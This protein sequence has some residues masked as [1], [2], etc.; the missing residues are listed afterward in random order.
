MMDAKFVIGVQ[1]TIM[2]YKQMQ[3]KTVHTDGFCL[4]NGQVFALDIDVYGAA[5]AKAA[6]QYQ[7]GDFVFDRR[8]NQTL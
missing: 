5:F 1:S 7:I 2:A 8:C 6:G 4:T 3:T